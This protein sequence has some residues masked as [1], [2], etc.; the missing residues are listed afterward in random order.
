MS[1]ESIL[2]WAVGGAQGARLYPIEGLKETKNIMDLEPDGNVVL[3][4]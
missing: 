3:H 1:L 4:S 2:G